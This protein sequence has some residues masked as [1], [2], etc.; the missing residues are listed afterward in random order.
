MTVPALK[1]NPRTLDQIEAKIIADLWAV[2][3]GETRDNMRLSSTFG[4]YVNIQGRPKLEAF[5]WEMINAKKIW[6]G[7]R[8]SDSWIEVRP[9]PAEVPT[10]RTMAEEADFMVRRAQELQ[11]LMAKG[12]VA[13]QDQ[14]QREFPH[15]DSEETPTP[16]N[17]RPIRPR[18]ATTERNAA[19][20]DVPSRVPAKENTNMAK[21]RGATAS[22]NETQATPAPAAKPAKTRGAAKPA[23]VE[24]PIDESEL[25]LATEGQ[26]EPAVTENAEAPE[27]PVRQPKPPK[28]PKLKV[29]VANVREGFCL[30][31]SGREVNPGRAFAQGGDARYKGL[32]QRVIKGIATPEERQIALHP[33]TL[34]HPKVV[35]SPFMQGLIQAALASGN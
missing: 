34:A 13:A 19:S 21:Q 28:E 14:W 3:A 32:L 20:A 7:S 16:D 9:I 35:G 33:F 22:V 1:Q 17:I 30:S 15:L 8:P 27:K 18:Q 12:S 6:F 24:V 26:T 29:S 4:V 2:K 31:G 23:V 5:L 25:S 10:P 11:R